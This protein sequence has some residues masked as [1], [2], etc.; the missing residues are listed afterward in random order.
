[1]KSSNKIIFLISVV[2]LFITTQAF[3]LPVAG[4]TI[5]MNASGSVP[6]TM[7]GLSGSSLGA[8]YQT[9]CLE[10]TNYFANN[11]EYT[12]TSVGEFVTGGGPGVSPP[13]DP[14]EWQTKWL[15]AA[16]MSDIFGTD[17][18][19]A[20]KVQNAIWYWEDELTGTE[21]TSAIGD[22]NFLNTYSFNASGWNV[23]AVNLTSDQYPD[24]QSQL[25]GVAPVPEPATMLL[26]G[27]GL[28]GLASARLRRKKK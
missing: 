5:K 4:D 1:M 23:V 7:T 22:W 10:K 8:I 13:G 12:V 17:S 21:I 14:L 11:A 2:T 15:Y 9:F 26:F 20:Q 3:A 24:A 6:Y 18:V 27:T 25:V 19:T 16:Y 28:I